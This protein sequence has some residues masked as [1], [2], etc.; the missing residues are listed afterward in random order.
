MI[1]YAI[2]GGGLE[3]TQKLKKKKMKMKMKMEWVNPVGSPCPLAFPFAAFGQV[4]TNFQLNN[5]C[6]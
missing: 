4:R 2:C 1:C 6:D 3:V 5:R